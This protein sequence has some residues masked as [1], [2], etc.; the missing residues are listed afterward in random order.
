[1]M[2]LEPDSRELDSTPSNRSWRVL[3]QARKRVKMPERW[4]PILKRRLDGGIKVIAE[5]S[6]ERDIT[7][8]VPRDAL[9][10]TERKFDLHSTHY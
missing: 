9:H 10:H 3:S 5:Y 2:S 1:M 4:L 6:M 7:K 8:G